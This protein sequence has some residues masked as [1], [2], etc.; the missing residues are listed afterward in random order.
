[1]ADS[2]LLALIVALVA[3]AVAGVQ[4]V[5]QIMSTAYVI[6]KCDKTTTGNLTG[7]EKLSWHWTQFRLTVNYEAI[8]FSLPMG[9]Y[10][11]LG[12]IPAVYKLVEP[13]TKDLW[14]TASR[15]QPNRSHACWVSFVLDMIEG[16]SRNHL[17][18]RW[19]S[20]DR[21]PE[22]LMLAPIQVD[23]ATVMLLC[24]ASGMSISKYSP[25][26]GE[27]SMSG[28]L[29][30]ISSTVHPYLGGLI[31]YTPTPTPYE[32]LTQSE[33]QHEPMSGDLQDKQDR[34][35]GVRHCH[36]VWANAVFGRFRD[37]NFGIGFMPLYELCRRKENFFKED[38]W[39][40]GRHATKRQA[41]CF[42][43]F[44]HVDVYKS[45]PPTCVTGWYAPFAEEIV[46]LHLCEVYL[47]HVITHSGDGNHL[48]NVDYV[49]EEKD[50]FDLYGCST[51]HLSLHYDFDKIYKSSTVEE[52]C[53]LCLRPDPPI[54]KISSLQPAIRLVKNTTSRSV[55]SPRADP[56]SYLSNSE[57]FQVI[58]STDIARCGIGR[59]LM[60]ED[61]SWSTDH[62]SGRSKIISND[63]APVHKL[64]RESERL[65]SRVV[66]LLSEVKQ[67]S[68]F[69]EAGDSQDHAAGWPMESV[70]EEYIK[71]ID[72]TRKTIPGGPELANAVV[73]YVRLSIL[74]AAYVTVMMLKAGG[75]GPGLVEGTVPVTALAYMA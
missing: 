52:Y 73:S 34:W 51:P 23:V 19:E 74:R 32:P 10:R 18:L 30:T 54:G 38:K 65:M 4:M 9:V 70:N 45:P 26:T 58:R 44:A 43:V 1:M 39:S 29:G 31:H 5:H 33:L 35:E 47:G 21:I 15:T 41:A 14:K 64:L 56:S 42:M 28:S 46:R 17:G 48:E 6:R 55:L 36:G 59:S 67:P 71:F 60:P 61:P 53:K 62:D 13:S 3:L 25:T 7:G 37:R 57:L 66:Y 40:Q 11:S 69:G 16:I 22:D 27:I 12:L 2:G 24:V 75:L 68:W 49:R 20:A 72:E 50:L 8:V 63:H